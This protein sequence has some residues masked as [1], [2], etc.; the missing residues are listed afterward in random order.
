MERLGMAVDVSH[1]SEKGFWDVIEVARKPI[2]ASHSCAKGL[3][4]HYRNLTEAQFMAIC[5]GGG[6]VGVNFYPLFLGGNNVHDIIK[7]ILYFLSLGGENHIGFGSD[8]DGIP[9]LPEGISGAGDVDK[10]INALLRENISEEIVRKITYAN[11]EKYF[12][13]VLPKA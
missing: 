6:V 11:M 2:I 1:I 12:L 9:N 8:F 10:I 13:K 7:H 5:E 3:C 4:P